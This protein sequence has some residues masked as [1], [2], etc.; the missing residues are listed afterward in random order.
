MGKIKVKSAPFN[1]TSGPEAKSA[2]IFH[3]LLNRDFIKGNVNVMD[4]VPNSDGI[5]TVTDADNYIIGDINVQLKTLKKKDIRNPKHQCDLS[6]L[7]Y[8]TESIL[9]VI[10]IVVDQVNNR[11]YWLHLN[12]EVIS[13]IEPHIRGK[14]ISLL[15]PPE[16]C[17]DSTHMYVKKWTEILRSVQEKIQ[18]FDIIETQL[19]N[20]KL[21]LGE[22]GKRLL[23]AYSLNGFAIREIH[24]FLDY[25]NGRL[26]R[27]FKAIKDL[28]YHNY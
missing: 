22:V 8:A 6:L 21:Q 19:N 7:T 26:D 2:D 23:P 16:N 24:I 20:L 4:K 18:N 10:L 11:A 27:E 1:K 17:I 12:H 28:L 13:Q 25:Y 9:P 3:A 14:T 15:L 5:L